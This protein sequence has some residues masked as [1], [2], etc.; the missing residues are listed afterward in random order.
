MGWIFTK[1]HV[2]ILDA[3]DVKPVFGNLDAKV[4]GGGS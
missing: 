2:S 4:R 3:K 1:D